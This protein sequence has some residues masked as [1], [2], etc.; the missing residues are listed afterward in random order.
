MLKIPK[1]LKKKKKG[2]KKKDQEL[3]TEEELEQYKAE[4]VRKAAEAAA[5][6]TE[7][8][9]PENAG[10]KEEWSKFAELTAG[11]DSVLKKTHDDLDRIK[12]TS[13]F[14]RK[15]PQIEETKAEEPEE[16]EETRRA[17]ELE[18]LKDAVVELSESEYESDEDTSF[19]DTELTEAAVQELP[20][21]Y[22]LESP[23]LEL[24]NGE[25]PFDTAYA[26]KVIKGPEVSK[27]GKKIV[28][29]GS[30]VL[31]VLTG[32]VDNLPKVA[33]KR[34]K[35]R[36]IQNLMLSSFDQG[37]D[38]G[39][40][41]PK[42]V[43][44]EPMND[45]L[46]SL[47]EVPPEE[48]ENVQIDLHANIMEQIIREQPKPEPQED[49][50]DDVLKEFDV[51]NEE[52]DEFAQLAA[53]SLSKPVDAIKVIEE[54]IPSIVPAPPPETTD[55]AEFE[56]TNDPVDV[57]DDFDMPDD[58]DD[59]F[60]TEFAEAVLPKVDSFEQLAL[61]S[62]AK[63]ATALREP[64]KPEPEIDLLGDDN[65]T[66]EITSSIL[67]DDDIIKREELARRKSSLS[68]SINPAKIVSFAVPTPDPLKSEIEFSA[69]I[70]KPLTPYYTNE[71]ADTDEVADI[72]PFDT[73]FVPQ[74][75][76]TKI[77]LNI[78]EQ[79]LLKTTLDGLEDDDFDPRAVTP[80][81]P[82]VEPAVAPAPATASI[83][84]PQDPFGNDIFE[85][86]KYSALAVMDGASKPVDNELNT[87]DILTTTTTDESNVASKVLTPQ[88][89]SMDSFE[90]PDID[91]FDTSFAD[92]KP[93]QAEIKVIESE[94]IQ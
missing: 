22:I 55:W 91:P 18:M 81:P 16:D 34:P 3:F 12:T 17:R 78:I 71:G 9:P 23:T 94:L 2:K 53:E 30:E 47:F 6:V 75:A 48:K 8:K 4:K 31:Q 69:L 46:D 67:T 5:A 19:F 89:N 90:I 44:S 49:K 88:M 10:D 76:P 62:L 92:T 20:A 7:G 82:Y 59:P 25:D 68:L 80:E 43:V 77:E 42:E 61:E 54:V 26:D 24:D 27:S 1:G 28:S 58:D 64:P 33:V 11:V 13:F 72:D 32:T 87:Q 57:E 29:L 93:G 70:K 74:A 65:P 83:Y 73:S 14:Q 36:G 41:A 21:A 56:P 84:E 45:P 15:A 35:R 40:G 39:D 38:E 51:L 50:D 63:K 52:D 60:N 79:D 85:D 86:D 66:I 37:D